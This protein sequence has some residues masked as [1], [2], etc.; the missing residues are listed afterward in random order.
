MKTLSS[1]EKKQ[2]NGPACAFVNHVTFIINYHSAFIFYMVTSDDEWKTI[3][4]SKSF[5]NLWITQLIKKN[6]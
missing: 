2:S 1:K 3:N 4:S 5:Y 6:K